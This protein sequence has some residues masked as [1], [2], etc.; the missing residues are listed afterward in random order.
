MKKYLL[1]AVKISISLGLLGYLLSQLDWPALLEKAAGLAWWTIPLAV[2]VLFLTLYIGTLRW[3]VLLRTHYTT[4]NTPQLFRHYL[5][6]TLFNNIL[7]TA[8]GGDLIRSYYIYRHNNDAV[9]AVSPI[10]TERVI[11][12]VVLLAINVAAIF[13]TD[14]VDIVSKALWSTLTLILAGA[15]ATLTLIA[16]PATY[17]PI[18]R[19]LERLARFRFIGFILRMG[20][21]THG[22]LKHPTTL[23]III[24]YSAAA[25]LFAVLVYYIL[26]QGL[27]VDISIQVILVVIPLAFM[28]AALPIS[29]G[30]MGVREL[31]TVGLLMRFGIAESDAA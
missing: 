20:E 28:A 24:L 23:L 2:S 25:Q 12:L 4:F 6:A 27:G 31:A 18:H 8:T 13:L 10:V 15:I 14:S 21:A 22:Y 26:A 3:A 5:V 16:L 30:G 17:W 11:G 9:C 1:L 29:I 19:L 7:P